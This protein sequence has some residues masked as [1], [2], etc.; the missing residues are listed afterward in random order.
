MSSN[1]S[2]VGRLIM[3]GDKVGLIVNE[4][5][6]GTWSEEPLFNWTTS[7]EI[8]YADGDRCIMT[9][10]SLKRMIDLGKIKIIEGKK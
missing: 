3:D 2:I 10:A 9:S 6:S 5:K 4:I 8:I 7:Y 1:E